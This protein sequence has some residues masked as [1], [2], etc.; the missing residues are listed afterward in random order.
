[1]IIYVKKTVAAEQCKK[2]LKY[3]KKKKSQNMCK[4]APFLVPIQ[5][6]YKI[7]FLIKSKT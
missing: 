5:R 4:K 2:C 1:M 6:F 3:F 7:F